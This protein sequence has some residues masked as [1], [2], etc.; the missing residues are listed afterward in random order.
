[1]QEKKIIETKYSGYFASE[2]GKIY[3]SPGKNDVNKQLNEHDLIELNSYLRGNPIGKQYQY[4]SVNISIRDENGN[5]IKQK[6][7]NVHRI[8][9][10]TFI[11]NPNNYDSVDHIDR[12]KHNNHVENLRWC[13]KDEN[14]K[15][16]ERDEE[17]KKRVS[18][19]IQQKKSTDHKNSPNTSC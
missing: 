5:F 15:S 10:E 14:M 8:I 4:P 9:A 11:P 12:N 2:D 3:R 6:K 16:W 18:N 13:T 1:M 17:Y 7:V 19:T